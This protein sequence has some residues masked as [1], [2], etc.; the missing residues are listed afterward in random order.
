LAAAPSATNAC[1][2][3]PKKPR[4]QAARASRGPKPSMSWRLATTVRS[5][6]AGRPG[7]GGLARRRLA[8]RYGA[9]ADALCQQQGPL[10]RDENGRDSRAGAFPRRGAGH[11]QQAAD[12]ILAP[13][14]GPGRRI[15]GPGSGHRWCPDLQPTAVPLHHGQLRRRDPFG[16][17]ILV[18]QRPATPGADRR[19]ALGDPLGADLARQPLDLLDGDDPAG[20]VAQ[21]LGG[22][23]ER[24]G[25]GAGVDDLG[26]HRRAERALVNPPVARL[27]EKKPRGSGRSSAGA[28][29]SSPRRRG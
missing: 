2:A 16:Q 25:V 18:D 21:V 11:A 12:F 15:T 6:A 22:A 27:G 4:P 9:P 23:G 10:G 20:Q 14:T 5:R 13:V 3:A 19:R 17:G 26:E 28:P 1:R 29:A 8:V 24:G 7:R